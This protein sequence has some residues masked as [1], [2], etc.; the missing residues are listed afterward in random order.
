MIESDEIT[1]LEN[2]LDW[3][4]GRRP[5]VK[6]KKVRRPLKITEYNVRALF[7][8]SMRELLY[9]LC[10]ELEYVV[11]KKKSSIEVIR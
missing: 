11:V 4:T 2:R 9:I 8:M 7:N 6:I 1:D 3:I 5:A 10:R